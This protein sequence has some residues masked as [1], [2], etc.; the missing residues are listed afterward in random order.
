MKPKTANLNSRT[1]FT[2]I[3]LLVVIAIIAILA[4]LLLPA[5][6]KAK[7]KAHRARCLSNLRQMGIGLQLYTDEN[8]EKFPF[9]DAFTP[10]G[11]PRIMVLDFYILIH[12]Y[13][14]TNASFYVCSTDRGPLNF[15]RAEVF[16]YKTNQ[17]PTAS[18]YTFNPGLSALVKNGSVS[19]RQRYATEVTYPSRKSTMLC[20]AI[21]SRKDI[22]GGFYLPTGHAPRNRIA[23]NLQFADGHSDFVPVDERRMQFDPET[24]KAGLGWNWSSPDWRDVRLNGTS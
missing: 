22:E 18:S 8:R 13:L 16:G 3:E 6:S 11:W 20:G 5:L 19:L 24:D 14:G 9:V 23:L 2:L 21:T 7:S 1:G 10:G 12:P 15:A 17:L 4:S